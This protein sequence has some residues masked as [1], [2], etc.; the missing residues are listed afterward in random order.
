MRFRT[1]A[2]GVRRRIFKTPAAV[3]ITDGHG[4]RTNVSPTR[5]AMHVWVYV[6]CPASP[7]PSSLRCRG[8]AN[9]DGAGHS[10]FR[11]CSR[12]WKL[13]AYPFSVRNYCESIR[14]R[15]P[16]NSPWSAF[17]RP[18][19][20][21]SALKQARF[22]KSPKCAPKSRGAF[23]GRTQ[24]RDVWGSNIPRNIYV[25]RVVRRAFL[26]APRA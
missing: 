10:R 20:V 8:S 11:T 1:T 4:P 3:T 18:R 24:R 14:R 5:D 16:Q 23:P 22:P 25:V 12:Q 21:G 15:S 2:G 7:F 19:R 17:R 6:Q 26:N 13:R 9:K